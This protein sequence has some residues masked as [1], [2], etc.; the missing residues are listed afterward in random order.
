MFCFRLTSDIT[1]IGRNRLVADLFL[2]STKTAGL[3]SRI[4]A[5]IIRTCKEGNEQ[6]EICDTSLNGTYVNDHK[7]SCSVLLKDGD[8]IAFGHIKGAALDPGVF[9]PQ[10]NSEFL[11]KVCIYILVYH[12]PSQIMASGP[13]AAWMTF[14]SVQKSATSLS[15][16]M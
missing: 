11:Y 9:A 10:K 4:H 14:A 6:Y 2:D 15:I 1:I 7:V 13:H 3:I 5:R 12:K 16:F 8:L